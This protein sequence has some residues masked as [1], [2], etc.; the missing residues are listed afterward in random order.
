MASDDTDLIQAL[1]QL[2]IEFESWGYRK[3]TGILKERGWQV[4]HKKVHRIWKEQGWQRRQ[5]VSRKAKHTGDSS[6]AAATVIQFAVT[7]SWFF[8]GGDLGC[9]DSDVERA[10]PERLAQLGL[11]V[12]SELVS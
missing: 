1:A 2:R 5:P 12:I 3:L 6:N 11:E 7:V 4:N 8:R 9:G 10:D